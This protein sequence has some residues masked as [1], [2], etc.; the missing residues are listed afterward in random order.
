[1][2][3]T[4]FIALAALFA[5]LFAA[6][7]A[8]L[9]DR[10]E[11]AASSG[12]VTL[13]VGIDGTSFRSALPDIAVS[14]LTDITLS[15]QETDSSGG[16]VTTLTEVGSWDSAAEMAEATIPFK[17]GTY[18]FTLTAYCDEIMFSET[19]SVTIVDGANT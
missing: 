8:Q 10:V 4:R 18:T 13:S 19:K 2:K 16:V 9:T 1:M 14:D 17:T 5:V 15:Y 7:C 6:G 11:T 3:K 12:T